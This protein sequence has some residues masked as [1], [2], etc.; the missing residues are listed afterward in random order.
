MK[1]NRIFITLLMLAL[2]VSG[3]PAGAQQAQPAAAKNANDPVEKIKDEGMNR[4][5]V[6]ETL[7]YLTD[8]IGPRLTNSPNMKRA[9]EWTR[10][11]LKGWGLENSHLEAW[12]PFGRGWSLKSFSAEVIA[13][14]SIPL[15]AFPKAWSNG[16]GGP[17]TADIVYVEAKDEKELEKYKGT[18]KGK[19]VLSAPVREVK[20]HFEAPAERM[21]EKQLLNLA[22]AQD[23]AKARQGGPQAMMNNPQM[24]EFIKS[25]VF[26]VKKARFFLD[27]GAAVVLSPSRSG[28]GG[29]IFLEDAGVPREV[30]GNSP[31]E[32][33][34]NLFMSRTNPWDKENHPNLPQVTIATEH[35]NRLI[36]MIKAGEKLQARINIDVQFHTDD[37][38]AY[39]TIAEIPGTS[40]KDEIVMVGAHMDSWH[41][42]T[43]ATDNGA[44]CAVAME[45]V[46]ILKALNLP[47]ARTVRIGLWSG[48][49]QGL[50]G[51][52]AYVKEHFGARGDDG[53][54]MAEMAAMMG[55]GPAAKI[56]SKPDYEKFSVYFNLD[57]GTGK[58]RGVYLQGNEAVRPIFRDWLMPFGEMGATTL[59]ISNTGGTDHLSF[60]AIGLPGFQFIQDEIEYDSRTHHSNMDVFDRIQ[61]DDMKQASVIMAAFLYQAANR[62]EKIPR[63]PMTK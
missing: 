7:S 44:G 26:D 53:S 57:N 3:F 45:A 46:R 8:V 61:A 18:L 14:Q 60:D 2:L 47:L 34:M 10:D 21:T 12:G 55:G 43:G 48:E 1:R 30:K 5:Q 63:K 9:N 13:P 36:R 49:E 25:A 35:S 28:D 62:D 31:M 11:K 23:P 39:N 17:V 58:I 51:S 16:T 33:M 40:K 6:M 20:A 15:I 56:N 24:A 29:T 4:S 19:V 50:F 41:S 59:T 52:R 38:M 22:N 32:Q 42:G 54:P 27:E 37:L